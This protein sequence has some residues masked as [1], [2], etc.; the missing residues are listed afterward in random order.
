MIAF[1]IT[2]LEPN[3]N[4]HDDDG[5]CQVSKVR[6]ILSLECLID[7]VH[8]VRLRHNEMESGN[9]SALKFSTLVSADSHRREALPHDGLA[10]V[11]SDEERNTRAETISLLQ[12]LIEH[13]YHETS[14]E[15]LSNDDD[16]A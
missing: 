16:G 13:Q 6:S 1:F 11:G 3:D 9:D 10:N 12:K 14:E 4:K 15:K 2:Y 7:A 8:R 5:G